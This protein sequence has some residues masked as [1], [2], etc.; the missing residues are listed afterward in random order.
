M[1]TKRTT[2]TSSSATETEPMP[3]QNPCSGMP[4]WMAQA[5]A[6]GL[7]PEQALAFIGLGLMQ[8]MAT[9]GQERPWMWSESEDGGQADLST[10]RQRLE[11]TQLAIH[12]GAP[13]TTAEVTQ[14]M[15]ARPGTAV[16]VR[17]G[18]T[19][20]RLSRNVWTLS[21]TNDDQNQGFGSGFGGD[22][23]R[24]RL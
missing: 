21:R 12:T 14:L 3:A 24:R 17:G 23:F 8:K 18:L 20:R 6:E 4:E 16:V 15:G 10:L 19:A 13:L 1:A 9:S 11:L 5:T 7:K 22:G 2:G